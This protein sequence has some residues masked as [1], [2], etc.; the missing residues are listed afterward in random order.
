M[1]IKKIENK[2]IIWFKDSNEYIVV[3]PLVAETLSLLHKNIDKQTIITKI[4]N[5]I[6]I[7]LQEIEN[8]IAD[9]NS[10]LNSQN[11]TKRDLPPILKPKKIE[12]EKF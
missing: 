8:L 10:L 2:N 7:P 3:E 6:N 9:I 11:S 4:S 12:Y 1:I 5:K